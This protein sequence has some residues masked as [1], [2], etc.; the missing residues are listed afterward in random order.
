MSIKKGMK[1]HEIWNL[2]RWRIDEEYVDIIKAYEGAI[3]VTK[4]SRVPHEVKI[5]SEEN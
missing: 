3:Y 1:K 4:E 2:F 5:I